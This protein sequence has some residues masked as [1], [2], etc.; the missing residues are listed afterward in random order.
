MRRMHAYKDAY[1]VQKDLAAQMFKDS[2]LPDEVQ[3]AWESGFEATRDF[4]RSTF[5][6]SAGSPCLHFWCAYDPMQANFN[7]GEPV[8][9]ENGQAPLSSIGHQNIFYVG[10]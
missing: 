9:D 5:A 4:V 3:C 8:F 2:M 10:T 1:K 6:R 7:A